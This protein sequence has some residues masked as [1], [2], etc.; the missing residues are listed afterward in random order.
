[1][2]FARPV[3]PQPEKLDHEPL[4]SFPH[5]T[6]LTSDGHLVFSMSIFPPQGRKREFL[7]MLFMN[8]ISLLYDDICKIGRKPPDAEL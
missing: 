6:P 5:F 8:R 2:Y 7:D 1:M 4:L 3:F